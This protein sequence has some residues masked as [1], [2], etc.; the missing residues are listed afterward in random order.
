MTET[1]PPAS[2]AGL[3]D[4]LEL[5]RPLVWIDLETTGIDTATDRIVELGCVKVYPDRRV[6]TYHRLVDPERPIPPDATRI[7]GITDEKVAGQ[8]SFRTIARELEAGLRDC[9]LGGYNLRRFDLRILEAEFQRAEVPFSR[10][11]RRLVDPMVVFMRNQGR[12]LAAASRFYLGRELETAHRATDDVI[13]AGLVLAA[14]LDRYPDLPRTL[15]ALHTY[16]HPRDPSWIVEEGKI[17]WR[18]GDARLRFGK[19]QRLAL[20]ELA[21]QERDYLQWI[22]DQ[23]FPSDTKQIIR[24]A[25]EGRF[26]LA[27]TDA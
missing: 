10:E 2:L 26:P 15:D 17:V 22:L 20:R 5:D 1:P 3:V 7:H 24:D 6:T 19:H 13:V 14:Q 25:L 21:E 9:D 27:P 8:P 11:G 12:D 4:R 16:C 18:D 23:D